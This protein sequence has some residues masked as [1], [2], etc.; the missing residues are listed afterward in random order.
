MSLPIQ[1]QGD[2]YN[3][4][5]TNSGE[6]IVAQLHYN[7]TSF[8]ELAANDTA[9][10]FYEPKPKKQFVL[11]GIVAR[12]D[13]QVS[14]TVDADV[15][16]YEASDAGSVTIIKTL[17]QVSMIQGDFITP[18]NLNILVSTGVFIN[19]KTTDDDIHMNILGYYIDEI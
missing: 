11:T 9:Y 13:K 6:L 12:A 5:V 14:S 16:V 1:I 2:R 19:A 4:K 3:A 15:I 8:N 7:E 18:T 10:N 17:F